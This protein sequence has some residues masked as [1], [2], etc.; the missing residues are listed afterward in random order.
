LNPESQIWELGPQPSASTKF[1]HLGRLSNHYILNRKNAASRL[2][3]MNAI[4][5]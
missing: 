5:V 1:R 4:A 3:P 2:V